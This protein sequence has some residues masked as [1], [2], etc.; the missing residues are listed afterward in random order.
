MASYIDKVLTHDERVLH[1]GNVSV[2]SMLGWLILGILTSVIGVGLIILLWI[3]IVCKTTELAITNKR[4]I[5]KTGFI[6]RHTVEINMAKVES[7]QVNQSLLGRI[8][9][10]GTLLIAGGGTPQAPV[11][12]VK[13]PIRFRQ[14]FM[15]AQ[16]AI[17][18]E[19]SATAS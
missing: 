19:R 7:V 4:V 11:V 2:L 8:F 15:E 14:A 18:A 1:S 6:S 9:N 17:N 5:T 16:D 10:Y 12:G 13:D 3:W